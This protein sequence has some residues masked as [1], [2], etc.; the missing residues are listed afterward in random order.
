MRLL[1]AITA[2]ILPTCPAWADVTW[3]L[4]DPDE[5]TTAR[6]MPG[7][8]IADGLLVSYS[9]WDPYFFLRLPEDE[10][11]VSG[12]PYLTARIYSSAEADRLDVYYRCGDGRWG[13][14]RTLP[15]HR[16]WAVYR[17]DLREAQWTESGMAA[18]ARQ[19]GGVSKRIMSF[20][21]DPGN[22]ADRWIV[23]DE[24]S[25]TAEPTGPLGLHPEPRGTAT[26]AALSAPRE[27]LAGRSISAQF[28]CRADTPAGLTDGLALLRLMSGTAPLQVHAQRVDLRADRVSLTHEFPI[29]AYSFGGDY[30]LFGEVLELDGEP[31]VAPVTVTNP[32]VGAAVPPVTRIA[33]YRGS[34][35]LFVNDQ[36]QPL[37]AYLHHGGKRG[38]LHREMAR[39]GITLYM[40]WFGASMAGNLGQIEPGVYEYGTFD[41]YFATVLDA[42]PDA[43]FI[44]HIGVTAPRWWQQM[45]PEECALFSD[46]RRGPSSIASERW[47]EEMGEDLRRLIAHLR[48]AP[49]ADRI[50]GVIF[51]SGHTAEWQMWGTWR[52]ESDDYSEPALREF[53]A[54]LR[55]KYGTDD[56]LRAAWADAEVTLDTA[57][58]PTHEQRQET[59]PFL[60]DPATDRQVIDFNQFI[61]DLTADAI[62]YF[63]RVTKEALDESQVTGTYYGYMAAHGAR[64]QDCGH[65]ALEQVLRSP[66]IDF[67]MSPPMYAH[68]Q[69][70]GTSTFMSATESVMLH[71]KLWLD[72]SDLRT[73]L[74][75]PASGYGRTSTPEDSV[76]VTWREFANVLTRRAAVS[77]FDMA[78]GWFSGEPMWDC[79]RRQVEV[80]R[81]AFAEREPFHGEIA[82]FVDERSYAYYR[83]NNLTRI[84]ITD[85]IARMP[86]V[87]VT[88]DFYLLSDLDHP[89]LPRYRLY[90]LLNAANMDE[91]T[92]RALLERA[93]RDDATVLYVYAP[94]YARED[95]LDA[96]RLE[97]FT[98]MS[99]DMDAPAGPATYLVEADHP[100]AE[101]L[102]PEAPLGPDVQL[103]PRPAI[104][105][106]DA[107]I[108]A[109]WTAGGVSMARKTH[110]GVNTVYCSAVAVPPALLRNIARA[111][112]AH[113]W[114]D[115][116]DG[117]YTDGRYFA[118]HAAADGDKTIRLP[119]GR[120]IV[121][122]ITGEELSPRAAVLERTMRRGETVFLRLE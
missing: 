62:N 100:L 72:E 56:A 103:A 40:D 42:V 79:Y 4:E 5:V 80:A 69:L 37:I 64:Q 97:A 95:R 39:T 63:A 81:E 104:T 22:E 54:W 30:A 48:R 27:T 118:L 36:P 101:G 91:A 24:V 9:E 84:M 116:G 90:V 71:G 33:D 41:S 29:S 59:L 86:E 35:T 85:V 96:A 109:R 51:Y 19:W 52:P 53:R 99:V 12:L 58:M 10:L 119:E 106:P 122:V 49:Y 89:T 21:L 2:A 65:N 8:T 66:D 102:A 108:I 74:S 3:T 93:R 107:E 13:L 120:R 32:R 111:A 68:R 121:D 98:G 18:D 38:V 55:G 26:E 92:H 28:S 82:V 94:G 67:L 87:G 83:F 112:G 78:G 76:A 47:R 6:N 50:L 110:E 20:R 115:T 60:R 45:H 7:L 34:P 25:L 14:G 105:D 16:G 88:W 57:A 44:P 43:Y 75:D 77:W 31:A 15:I 1:L 70:G 61:S 11:D 117:I 73:Y 46:G 17:A 114:S 23:V 113:V